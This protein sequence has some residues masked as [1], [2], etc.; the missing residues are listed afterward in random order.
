MGFG[1]IVGASPLQGSTHRGAAATK[2]RDEEDLCTRRSHA[3]SAGSGSPSSSR[4][5]LRDASEDHLLRGLAWG[6]A[7]SPDLLAPRRR[8]HSQHDSARARAETPRSPEPGLSR[9]RTGAT[10]APRT[11]LDALGQLAVC[12]PNDRTHLHELVGPR[13]ETRYAQL[14]PVLALISGLVIPSS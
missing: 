9:P 6:A 10:P 1:R 4:N 3:R 7:A 14:H 13:L 2:R 11:D 12:K 8:T 5:R